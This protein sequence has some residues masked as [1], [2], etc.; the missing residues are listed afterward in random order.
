MIS[1]GI[2]DP[3]ASEFIQSHAGELHRPQTGQSTVHQSP[4]AGS[5]EWG[6]GSPITRFLAPDIFSTT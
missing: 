3:E 1:T 5:G 6:T 2:K 4:G